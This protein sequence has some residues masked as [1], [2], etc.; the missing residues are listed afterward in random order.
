MNRPD[1]AR[2]APCPPVGLATQR[3]QEAGVVIILAMLVLFVL[4]V[5]VYQV[6]MT[7]EVELEQA[8][9]RVVR[10]QHR[11]LAE[12]CSL[13]AQSALLIDLEDAAEGEEEAG[14]GGDAS[15]GGF[16]SDGGFGE[17]DGG[18]EGA[19]SAA[20]VVAATDSGLD[21]W[22]DPAAIAPPLGEGLTLFIEIVDEDSKINLLGLW[23]ED[24]ERQEEWREIF[25]RLLDEAF[26]GTSYDLSLSNSLDLIDDLDEW[27]EGDRELLGRRE[28]PELKRTDAEDAQADEVDTDIIE[29]DKVHFPLSLSELLLISEELAPSHLDGFVEDD[30]YYPGLRE[31]LTVWTHLELKEPAEMEDDDNPFL[32]SP[33]GAPGDEQDQQEEDSG[34]LAASSTAA[35]GQINCNTAP[36]AVLRALAHED[37]PTS[38]LEKVVEFR[39]KL[40]TVR[41]ELESGDRFD[42]EEDPDDP[43]AGEL[44]EDDPAFYVFQDVDELFDKVSEEWD[45]SVFTDEAEKQLFLG[46][47][48]VVSEVFTVKIL[49]EDEDSGRRSTY[50]TVIWRVDAEEPRCVVLRPLEAYGDTR[51]KNDYPDSV[52][53]AGED[54]FF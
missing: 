48:G 29:N 13:T 8:N 35:N 32:N 36:L 51:R 5:V 23:C 12:A 9:Q 34:E 50:R 33:L 39:E 49:I 26:E 21:E 16:G 10:A 42:W 40:Q 14:A 28:P 15:A 24:E 1:P 45:L 4:L 47:M 7:A 30:V 38:F 6:F 3:P 44:D 25:S 19:T 18:E 17:E 22:A 54:R 27:V 53:E 52:G 41:D 43:E 46:R 11:I 37:I 31:M 20:E 2:D